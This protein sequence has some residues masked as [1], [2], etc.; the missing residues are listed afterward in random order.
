MLPLAPCYEACCLDRKGEGVSEDHLPLPLERELRLHLHHTQGTRGFSPHVIFPHALSQERGLDTLFDEII[1][2]PA[3]WDSS[4]LLKLR[5]RVDPSGPQHKCQ[6]GCSPNMC[7]GD[8]RPRCFFVSRVNL[9]LNPLSPGEELGAFL[10]RNQPA[11]DRVVYIGDGSND[12]CPILRLRR[13]VMPRFYISLRVDVYP[14]KMPSSVA[15]IEAS[16][17]VLQRRARAKASEPTSRT[18]PVLGR[19]RSYLPNYRPQGDSRLS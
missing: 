2:N 17:S 8:P 19:S 11:F 13:S 14:V 6:V 7:K 4:G 15:G 10:A 16:R 9:Q 1:T 3:Q 12:F 18:G 5:R